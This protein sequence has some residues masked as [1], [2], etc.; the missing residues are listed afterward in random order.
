MWQQIHRLWLIKI[1]Q[2]LNNQPTKTIPI[3]KNKPQQ[4]CNHHKNKTKTNSHNI[5]PIIITTTKQK[6][7]SHLTKQSKTQIPNINH[8]NPN[9][10]PKTQ[11]Q[12]KQSKTTPTKHKNRKVYLIYNKFHLLI[13]GTNILKHHL[14]SQIISSI[15]RHKMGKIKDIGS[16]SSQQVGERGSRKGTQGSVRVGRI[17]LMKNIGKVCLV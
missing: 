2:K 5:I 8:P 13:I 7:S 9:K 12:Q 14:K 4:T 17:Y 10:I 11:P 3:L 1:I 6:I 15:I 16:R